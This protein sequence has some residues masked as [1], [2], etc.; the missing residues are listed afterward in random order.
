MNM[1]RI[2][3]KRKEEL[4]KLYPN[5]EAIG[6]A[7]VEEYLNRETSVRSIHPTKKASITYEEINFLADNL[8]SLEDIYAY[9]EYADLCDAVFSLS[10]SIDCF[11]HSFTEGHYR[12]LFYIQPVII[13]LGTY[14]LSP[15]LADNPKY[16]PHKEACQNMITLAE[17]GSL[18]V[19][20]N[21]IKNSVKI[22]SILDFILKALGERYNID[23]DILSPNMNEIIKGINNLREEFKALQSFLKNYQ[24]RTKAQKG[25]IKIPQKLTNSLKKILE[26]DFREWLVKQGLKDMLTTTIQSAKINTSYINTLINA[27]T[28]R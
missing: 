10:S 28:G 26:E 16:E 24:E 5:G 19:W 22:L 1:K 25:H 8:S 27:T 17:D 14:Y 3:K 11:K 23:F 15:E 12:I 21:I 2:T 20:K 18:A 9:N 6:R 4:L 7:I 13:G